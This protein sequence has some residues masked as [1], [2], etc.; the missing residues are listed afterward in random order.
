MAKA[1]ARSH[2]T[3]SNAPLA[4]SYIRM[5][6]EVQLKG[7]SRRRQLQQSRSFAERHGLT[8]VE[9]FKLED[10]GVSAFKGRNAR[11]G[12]LKRF[13][14][15]VE[16][17]TITPGSYL[18]VESLDRLSRQKPYIALNLFTSIID[19]GIIIASTMD[20]EV[21]AAGHMDM[22]KLFKSLMILGR[23]N[24]ESV[25]KR[26]RGKEVWSKKRAHYDGRKL[27]AKCPAW[28][29]LDASRTAFQVLDSRA[30]TVHRIFEESASGI[31]SFSIA[32]RLNEDAIPPFGRSD[33]WQISYV[34]K[35]LSSRA[36]LGEFRPHSIE[37]AGQHETIA[38]RVATGAP[39]TDYFPRIVEEELFYRAQSARAQRRIGGGGR[40]GE[41]VSNLF[42]KLA[43]CA[44]CGS[45]MHFVNRGPGPKGGSYLVCDGARR[46]VHQCDASGWRYDQFEAA[47]LAYVRELDLEAIVRTADDKS[48]RA[49]LDDEIGTLD[50]R[51]QEARKKLENTF[52][53]N[54]GKD[55]KKAFLRNKI[56][57][58]EEEI[59][60]LE[61]AIAK[62]KA[63][64][65][66]EDEEAA[67]FYEGRDEI[68]SLIASLSDRT[69]REVY[70]L[71]AQIAA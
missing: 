10:I 62:K 11:Q 7:D 65:R 14:T 19:A 1:S 23:S 71:R 36:V 8:L 27:T 2:S 67:R 32:R 5:S 3:S 43:C 66:A 39:I 42:S 20:G 26:N 46:K 22:D 17:G 69:N 38:R 13:L 40:R 15:L 68:R 31:G 49:A 58:F 53:L 63:E 55:E 45:K 70:S 41:F 33:G 51:L 50:G 21:Y 34:N 44:Y 12:A 54:I 4:Y 64:R 25:T 29:R 9:D 61:T 59:A 18:L 48:R 57:Q 24:D 47:F 37:Y 30:A 6:T 56:A 60:G 16:E 35:I 52:D 28:L